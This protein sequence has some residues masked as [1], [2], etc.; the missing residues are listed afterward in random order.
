MSAPVQAAAVR[1]ARHPWS[2]RRIQVVPMPTVRAI[3]PVRGMPFRWSFNPYRGCSHACRYCYAR[4][5]HEYLGYNAGDDFDRVILAKLDAPER[6]RAELSQPSWRRDR[7]A[8]GTATDPYQPVEGRLRLTRRAIEV[9][10]ERANPI[11]LVT[12]STLVMRD[13]DLL[14]LLSRRAPGTVVWVSVTTLD[15]SL[16][17]SVEPGA[18]PPHQ[19]LRAVRELARAGVPAGVL[20]APVLPGLTDS[21]QQIEEL[22]RVAAEA[23]ACD[24]AVH[25]LRLCEGARD[26]YR[27]WLLGYVPR[28]EHLYDRLYPGGSVNVAASYH[29]SLSETVTRVKRAIAFPGEPA[30][31]RANDERGSG[32]PARAVQ[33]TLG[34]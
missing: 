1:P 23:G 4:R 5:T 33:L 26:V 21:E 7:I 24:V 27:A 8:V 10:V 11:S 9:F 19:R 28:L 17:R 25:P 3:N 16:A 2:H 34:W 30:A 32:A 22:V 6:L 15:R 31:E 14:A 12:K 18:P 20:I 29:A 13:R